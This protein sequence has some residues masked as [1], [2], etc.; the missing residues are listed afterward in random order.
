MTAGTRDAGPGSMPSWLDGEPSVDE[1][2]LALAYRVAHQAVGQ[3]RRAR[4]RARGSVVL[5]LTSVDTSRPAKDP[6][7]RGTRAQV[8]AVL[9]AE[10]GSKAD[11]A[12]L[13]SAVRDAI[14][15]DELALLPPRQRYALWA[16]A[17]AHRS[18]AEVTDATGWTPSQVA[19]L[20][21]AALRTVATQARS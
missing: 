13:A 14:L 6:A 16:T 3:S 19:R 2:M 11:P 5:A 7:R 4:A 10:F 12:R 20:V 9:Q 18:V 17:L 21:R 15:L 8:L 1:R